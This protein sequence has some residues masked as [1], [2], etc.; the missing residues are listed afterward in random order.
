MN[1]IPDQIRAKKISL[2]LL[3]MIFFF[4]VGIRF[5][6]VFHD[7]PFSFFGDELHLIKR[8][9]AI[10]SGDLNPH[11]FHK[12]AFLMY[13][14]TFCYGILFATGWLFGQFS[15]AYEFGSYFLQDQGVF[16]LIG[17]MVI[18]TFGVATVYTVYKMTLRISDS[19]SASM[20]STGTAAVLLPMVLGSIVVK[21]DVPAG[22]FVLLSVYFFMA[23]E[24]TRDLR[25]LLI[26][27]LLAGLAMGTKY[28]GVVLLP[29]FMLAQ[30]IQRYTFNSSWLETGYRILIIGSLFIIGFFMVS[31]YNFLD[32]LWSSEIFERLSGMVSKSSGE[33]VYD[34]DSKITFESGLGSVPGA[35]AY[36]VAQLVRPSF[37]GWPLTILAGAGLIGLFREK[38]YPYLFNLVMPLAFYFV[39]A[40]VAAPY[41]VSARHLNGVFPLVCVLVGPG[42]VYVTKLLRLSSKG[43]ISVLFIIACIAIL[44]A[45]VSSVQST[46]DKLRID[47]RVEAHEWILHNIAKDSVILLDDHGPVLQPNKTTAL[48][49]LADLENFPEKDAFT[50]HQKK[51]LEIISEFPPQDGFDL[52][53][54]GHQ[55]WLPS[56]LTDEELRSSA[57][58]RDMGNPL[59]SRTPERVSDYREKGVQYIVT[60]SKAQS[61]YSDSNEERGAQFPSFLRFYGELQQFKPIHTVGSGEHGSKGPKIFIYDLSD[62][63]DF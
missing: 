14:L 3:F 26:A 20:I 61:Y 11:W 29:G 40:S 41:H 33:L 16:L 45:G 30:I 12:P 25:P 23:T 47:S 10:G 19:F 60:N 34:P 42:A 55:W 32:P 56:E 5:I 57:K 58:H 6:G 46:M 18:A 8:A 31:P 27:S 49:L 36:L 50:I 54:L 39:I 38:K 59:I 37:L 9:M 22:F 1:I 2:L 53:E 7:L 63:G 51:R 15:S 17:R 48:R 24:K 13:I 21:A 4:A 52:Y 62:T 44:P 43:S 28:F 35:L